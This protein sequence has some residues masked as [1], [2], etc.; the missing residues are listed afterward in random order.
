MR[1]LLGIVT[2]EKFAERAFDQTGLAEREITRN[3]SPRH[4]PAAI[5]NPGTG[6][7]SAGEEAAADC[8]EPRCVKFRSLLLVNYLALDAWF[9][10]L[11]GRISPCLCHDDGLIVMLPFAV[12]EFAHGIQNTFEHFASL[13]CGQ[14]LEC[15]GD[16]LFAK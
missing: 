3:P 7:K 11:E 6:T 2:P 9:L 14:S 5:H 1:S 12:A 4:M 10:N 16:V 15:A 13:S 8:S